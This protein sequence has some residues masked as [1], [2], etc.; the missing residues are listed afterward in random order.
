MRL[1]QHDT[2]ILKS[3]PPF[4][5]WPQIV[6][7]FLE[8]QGLSYGKF[9]YFFEEQSLK[10]CPRAV[11]DCPSLGQPVQINGGSYGFFDTWVLSNIHTPTACTEEDLLPLMK[12]LH[13]SYGFSNVT[14]YY[15]DVDFFGRVIPT[16]RDLSL[17]RKQAQWH[18][19]P[20]DPTIFLD[21]QLR[22]SGLQLHR[23]ILGNNTLSMSTDVLR[24]GK[25]LDPAP[26]VEAM[27]A[28]LPGARHR[29]FQEMV[30]SEEEQA[31]IAARNEAAAPLL[32]RVHAFFEARLPG[33][34]GQ[35]RFP[36][37]YKVAPILKKLS[38]QYGW[39]YH[40]LADGIFFMTK[41]TPKGQTLKLTADS[42]PSRYD[43]GFYLDFQGLGYEH[44]LWTAVYLPT[45]QEE[46]D[47]AAAE[48]FAAAAEFEQT[49]LLAELTN[50]F[51]EVPQWL[52]P[53]L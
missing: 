12:K 1:I 20:L 23:D 42:G 33:N 21:D 15:L 39:N 47:R 48:V 32:E 37:Q 13:R 27:K 41:T 38:K 30:L 43:T 4:S 44:R 25:L 35:N 52:L 3:K 16:E 17:A 14:L 28:L 18:K 2:F 50:H 7:R 11:K 36:S 19:K 53:G 29:S 34:Q 31:E 22:G 9:Y 46:L 10:G 26:Y 40:F 6:H 5:E 8:E 51:P 45:S 49:P 24:D